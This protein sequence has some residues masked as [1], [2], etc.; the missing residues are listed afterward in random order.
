[1]NRMILM[2]LVKR[3][4]RAHWIGRPLS[5]VLGRMKRTGLDWRQRQKWR[6]QAPMK[7]SWSL[8]SALASSQKSHILSQLSQQQQ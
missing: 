6:V 1:M 8:R 7:N 2:K 4:G 5:P 3:S